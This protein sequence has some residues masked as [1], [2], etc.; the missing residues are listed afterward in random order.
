MDR[1]RWKG[2]NYLDSIEHKERLEIL[3]VDLHFKPFIVPSHIPWHLIHMVVYLNVVDL[4]QVNVFMNSVNF[5]HEHKNG[6]DTYIRNG[7]IIPL[8]VIPVNYKH[9]P[10]WTE[11]RKCIPVIQPCILLGILGVDRYTFKAAPTLLNLKNA[12]TLPDCDSRRWNLLEPPMHGGIYT[13]NNTFH[14]FCMVNNKIVY[15]DQRVIANS[16][17]HI[18]CY[19]SEPPFPVDMGI[20]IK[21]D[22]LTIKHQLDPVIYESSKLCRNEPLLEFL[23]YIRDRMKDGPNQPQYSPAV[24][25]KFK[26]VLELA[27]KH[28]LIVI[29]STN[30]RMVLAHFGKLVVHMGKFLRRV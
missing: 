16:W 1:I 30:N 28:K 13:N 19:L 5:T 17:L 25:T 24:K 26:H 29:D 2:Q 23:R 21:F 22:D 8:T 3:L 9:I 27:F 18:R 14:L 4:T 10:N 15:C 20:R 6:V 7:Q 12:V 11:L